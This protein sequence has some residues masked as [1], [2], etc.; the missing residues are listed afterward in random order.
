MDGM[1]SYQMAVNETRLHSGFTSNKKC[2]WII[3]SFFRCFHFFSRC[4]Q[5]HQISTFV[6]HFMY[7]VNILT[8]LETKM[9]Q[10]APECGDVCKKCCSERDEKR[11]FDTLVF[12]ECRNTHHP[13]RHQ[14]NV[15]VFLFV[16][17][18]DNTSNFTH[19]FN[20]YLTI[21]LVS[22]I[23]LLCYYKNKIPH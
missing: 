2:G 20:V 16:L 12:L 10:G 3:H 1:F 11:L 21:L 9:S 22:N 8:H 13:G 19:Q 5:K 17:N 15:V 6:A 4:F 14:I 23:V 7:I 18:V